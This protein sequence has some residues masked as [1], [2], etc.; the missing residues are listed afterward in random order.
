MYRMG[1]VKGTAMQIEKTLIHG[2]HTF[3]DFFHFF[4]E[5]FLDFLH[6]I[7]FLRNKNIYPVVYVNNSSF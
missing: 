6:K 1:R 4:H 5:F 2:S 3:Q 7:S